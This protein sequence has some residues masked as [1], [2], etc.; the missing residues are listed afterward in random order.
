MKKRT[1]QRPFNKQSE[2]KLKLASELYYLIKYVHGHSKNSSQ[3]GK[4]TLKPK[5][6]TFIECALGMN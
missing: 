4:I 2:V 5:S 3:L 1:G 6:A